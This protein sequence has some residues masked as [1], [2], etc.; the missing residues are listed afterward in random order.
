MQV[1]SSLHLQVLILLVL[2]K[3]A[4]AEKRTVVSQQI[5]CNH[6]QWTALPAGFCNAI[7]CF[8]IQGIAFTR[9]IPVQTRGLS[10]FLPSRVCACRSFLVGSS[11]SVTYQKQHQ[12]RSTNIVDWTS[13]AIW[14]HEYWLVRFTVFISLGKMSIQNLWAN[15]CPL[16]Y[17]QKL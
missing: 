17:R 6:L 15:T 14:N 8:Y 7:Q 10:C 4:P 2:W 13:P 3:S 11:Q 5:H 12:S 9:S 1:C 16:F